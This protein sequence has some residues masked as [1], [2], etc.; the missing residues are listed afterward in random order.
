MKITKKRFMAIL[1]LL[2]I[3]DLVCVLALAYGTKSFV[4]PIMFGIGWTILY[5]F[6]IWTILKNGIE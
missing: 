3:V 2:W 5:A 1:M 6:I 4:Y